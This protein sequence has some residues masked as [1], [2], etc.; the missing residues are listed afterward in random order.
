MKLTTPTITEPPLIKGKFLLGHLMD[1][2]KEGVYFYTRMSRDHGDALRL[3]F[4]HQTVYLFFNPEHNKEVLVDK[5]DQFIKGAQYEPLRLLLGNGLLT[6]TG[7]DWARQRRML[8]PIFGK[9]GMDILL[10]HISRISEK[11]GSV[12][13]DQEINWT[14]YMFEFTL[15]VAFASFFGAIFSDEQKRELLKASSDCIRLVSKRMSNVINPPMYFPLKEHRQ[16]RKSY[17]FLKKTVEEIYNSRLHTSDYPS[18]DLLDLLMKAQDTESGIAGENKKLSRDEVWDQILSFLMAGHETT[19]LT[20]SWLFYLLAQNPDVQEKIAIECKQNDFKFDNSL[21]LT[22]YPY[23]A[24]VINETMRLYPSGWILA[25]TAVEDA[26]VG[27]F[28]VKKGR[29]IA[30]SPLVTHRDPRWWKNPEE[31]IPERFLEGHALFHQAPKNAFI[32]FSIGKRNCIGA[33]FAL[34]EIALFT[35]NFFKNDLRASSSQTNVRMKG[36]V[37][38]KSDKHVILTIKK[39]N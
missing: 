34:L 29:S 33:R 21:S 25:R 11:Y 35:I 22:Q 20:M 18:K 19:A 13:A 36:F 1:A 23:L 6:A 26:T 9:D 16:F 15:E 31:F 4:G 5:A 24:A 27:G 14:K 32:P 12:G 38:L 28:L 10:T 17:L 37:T 8:N 3:K 7:S 39:S 2:K 30:V